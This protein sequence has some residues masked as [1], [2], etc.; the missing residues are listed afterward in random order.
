MVL[1]PLIARLISGEPVLPAA[2]SLVEKSENDL[3]ALTPPPSMADRVIQAI[4]A[5]EMTPD[6]AKQMI[7]EGI[8]KGELTGFDA[9]DL[10]QIEGRVKAS[11]TKK[12]V[13]LVERH[14]E[15]AVTIMRSWMYQ[16][17]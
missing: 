13:E 10:A 2:T 15:E 9:I 6:Q 12:L 5:G 3:P 17:A 7:T 8:E 1:R 16:D 4:E 14:P 11:S